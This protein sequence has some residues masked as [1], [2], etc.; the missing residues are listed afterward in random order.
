M[1]NI[2]PVRIAPQD[3]MHAC[4]S[5]NTGIGERLAVRHLFRSQLACLPAHWVGVMLYV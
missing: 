1:Q 5:P 4:V 2:D 3:R